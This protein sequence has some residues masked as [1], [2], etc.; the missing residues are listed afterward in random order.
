MEDGDITRLHPIFHLTMLLF[1]LPASLADLPAPASRE[2]CLAGQH[3]NGEACAPCPYD[4]VNKY[5]KYSADAASHCNDCEEDSKNPCLCDTTS[6]GVFDSPDHS[7]QQACVREDGTLNLTRTCYEQVRYV[8]SARRARRILYWVDF[9]PCPCTN[10]KTASIC[11]KSQT[12]IN[13]FLLN[14]CDWLRR[15]KDGHY[16]SAYIAHF[17]IERNTTDVLMSCFDRYSKTVEGECSSSCHALIQP[18]L[19]RLLSCSCYHATDPDQCGE[20][21]NFYQTCTNYTP[22]PITPNWLKGVISAGAVAICLLV[23]YGVTYHLLRQH[24]RELKRSGSIEKLL[25]FV[26]WGKVEALGLLAK[27]LSDSSRASDRCLGTFSSREM[28]FKVPFSALGHWGALGRV[29]PVQHVVVKVF[30]KHR[31]SE[32]HTEMSIISQIGDREAARA[33]NIISVYGPTRHTDNVYGP[34]HHS[35]SDGLRTF[36]SRLVAGSSTFTALTCA[37][38]EYYQSVCHP[39]H[40]IVM[41]HCNSLCL[42]SLLPRLQPARLALLAHNLATALHFLHHTNSPAIVHCDIKPDNIFVKTRRNR[43]RFILGDFGHAKTY[44]EGCQ[45]VLR[46]CTPPFIP[47]EWAL[48]EGTCALQQDAINRR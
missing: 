38:D 29:L 16:I 34:T 19:P 7:A 46:G 37:V 47:P 43:T 28:V 3:W 10:K 18:Y 26:I 33:A 22:P 39:P 42:T 2:D 1:L 24:G 48:D 4:P 13:N 32:Q 8:L 44:R 35:D 11:E 31:S 36:L 6:I 17:S 27:V 14:D 45:W 23:S 21:Y 9:V 5:Y 12:F 15:E 25:P 30:S 41:N 40:C 20:Y